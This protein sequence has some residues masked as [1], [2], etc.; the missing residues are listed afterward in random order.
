MEFG[1]I[2]Y[3]KPSPFYL[4]AMSLLQIILIAVALSMDAMAV[5]IGTC[6]R[7]NPPSAKTMLLM[8]A[9]FG[10]FQAGMPL[11]GYGLGRAGA[12]LVQFADHWIA[13]GLLAFVGGK[14]LWE[15]FQAHHD[16]E[17]SDVSGNISWR[18]LLLL[19]VATSID[20]GAVGISL[21]LIASPILIPSLMIGVITFALS[22]LG[23]RFGKLLG[24]KM[25][26][27]AEILGGLVL[28]GIGVKILLEHLG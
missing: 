20:A 26:K 2:C 1:P 12:G 15:G 24:E 4:C 9:S 18:T 21:S 23:G 3:E 22:W 11:L 16:D 6:T 5:S 27:A 14:L 8:A 19:S 28:I 25:G 13:F 17:D 7:R 10:V